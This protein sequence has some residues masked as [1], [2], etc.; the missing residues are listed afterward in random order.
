M[1]VKFSRKKSTEACDLLARRLADGAAQLAVRAPRLDVDERDGHDRSLQPE[2]AARVGLGGQ[3]ELARAPLDEADEL[4]EHVVGQPDGGAA[5][6]LGGLVGGEVDEPGAAGREP[7][8]E[9]SR[10]SSAAG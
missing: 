1:D 9:A 4:A 7:V 3:A 5:G 6:E 8:A 10:G 2:H